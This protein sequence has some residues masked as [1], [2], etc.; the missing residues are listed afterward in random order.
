MDRFNRRF[1]KVHTAVYVGSRGWVGHRWTVV[2]SLV[3]HTTGRHSGTRRSVVL[4]YATDGG[5]LLVVGSN[6]GRDRPPAWLLNLEADQ[7]VSVNRGH[8][9]TEVRAEIVEPTDTRYP[10]L[11]AIA[12]DNNRRRFD[13]YRT[14]TDRAIPVVVLTPIGS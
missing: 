5:R 9:L 2:P 14:L 8:R 3:L 4:V 7:R 1:T 11:F 6:F 10:R 12:N 13:R